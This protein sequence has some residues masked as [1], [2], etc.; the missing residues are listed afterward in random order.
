[1]FVC[2]IKAELIL[3]TLNKKRGLVGAVL[4]AALIGCG[5]FVYTTVGG[6]V[7]G[8]VENST[9]YLSDDA[10]YSV[11]VSAD[12]SFSFK[13]AS[14]AAYNIKVA[15]QPNLVN[16]TVVN[17][18][19]KMSSDAPV[20]NIAVNCLPNVAVGG[21]ISGMAD[22]KSI[23]LALDGVTQTPIA[24]NGAFVIPTYVVNNKPYA[25]TLVLPPTEQVCS[26]V[27]GTGTADINK[28]TV[29]NST[30]VNCVPGVP[31]GGTLAGLKIGT[32]VLLS[33]NGKNGISLNVDG[34]FSFAFSLLDGESYDVQ[35][36]TQ[37]IGQKCTVS[38][39]TGK[40]ILSN[41]AASKNI[42]VTCIAG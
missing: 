15:Q 8:L 38:N 28:P 36:A 29:A 1:V 40:V 10:G 13:V 31:V 30:V 4:L 41:P 2:L 25:I 14:N 20:T 18:S 6:T 39:G 19:G 11:A 16:C 22:T 5:G 24:A 3:I 17:G 23:Y 33:N 12:G 21:T 26:V 42:V 32:A 37:P 9:V 7:K 27:N 34:T 35:V